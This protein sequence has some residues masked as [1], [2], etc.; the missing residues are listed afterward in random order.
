[1][2]KR[3]VF[4]LVSFV[5]VLT[6]IMAACG[7][8]SDSGSTSYEMENKLSY[9][10]AD[11]TTEETGVAEAP[12]VAPAEEGNGLLTTTGSIKN[13]S[14]ITVEDSAALQS[15]DK[16]IRTFYMDVETQEFDALITKLDSEMGRLNGYVEN[17]KISGRSFNDR[18]GAR[19]ASI[20][21]RIPRDK[22][23]EF[24]NAVD[25]SAN[26]IN[27]QEST[28]NVTL[29]YA[30]IESRKKSLEIEQERLFVLLEKADTL[31][32][33]VTLESRLSEIRYQ[34]QNYETTLRTYD[35]KVEY[36]TVT[37]SIQ[38]VEKLSPTVEMKQTVGTRITNGFSETIYNISEGLQNLLVWFVVNLP[39]L[40]I[41][42]VIIAAIVLI[43][44]RVYK[45]YTGEDHPKTPPTPPVPP[46]N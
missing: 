46:T 43:A 27:K 2:K 23:D 15:Q 13:K 31:E 7:K 26:V 8:K 3:R 16:I 1:M 32:S 9:D 22:V 40:L 10:M 24:V 36:S 44:R 19:I 38:E 4:V 6:M 29:E 12:A 18:E 34:L 39:Y 42:T 37:L 21:V 17:S 33:I 35:N 14:A 25:E 41:W 28:E 30:D 45:K 5:I 11:T 20:T